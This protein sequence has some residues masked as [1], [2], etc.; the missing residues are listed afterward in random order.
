MNRS[1]HALIALCFLILTSLSYAASKGPSPMDPQLTRLR[2]F[3]LWRHPEIPRGAIDSPFQRFNANRTQVKNR[4]IIFVNDLTKPR[5]VLRL[6]RIEMQW[7]PLSY[8][9]NLN[10]P[11]FS[12]NAISRFNGFTK[13]PSPVHFMYS[14]HGYGSSPDTNNSFLER[15]ATRFG[16]RSKE[17]LSSL[18]AF[19]TGAKGHFQS[20]SSRDRVLLFGIDSSN[21]KTYSRNVYFHAGIDGTGKGWTQSGTYLNG[22]SAGC[23]VVSQPDYKYY[24]DYLD[25]NRG[26]MMYN[27]YD[28]AEQKRFMDFDAK[29]R[30]PAFLQMAQAQQ[31]GDGR[32]YQSAA[33]Q[34]S[35][36]Y[37]AGRN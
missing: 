3:I 16:N 30:Y 21:S 5:D 26:T 24:E 1:I 11:N 9:I 19:I 23:I 37:F 17:G 35:T 18:G 25:K 2:N 7:D 27:W 36:Y 10:D 32:L 33:K 4:A 14:A 15:Y 12:R 28:S 20:D 29:I 22:N 8:G 31:S 34:F 13:I 6:Y